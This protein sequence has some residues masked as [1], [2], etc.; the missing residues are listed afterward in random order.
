MGDCDKYDHY[1]YG[2]GYVP[3][4][5]GYLRRILEQGERLEELKWSFANKS[6]AFLVGSWDDCN[7]KAGRE[8]T[9]TNG[10]FCYHPEPHC[11]DCFPDAPY[12]VDVEVVG[13]SC[14][15]AA[16]LNHPYGQSPTFRRQYPALS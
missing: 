1:P 16:S 12:G 6:V 9:F 5:Y 10:P 15:T 3:S 7:C 13:G 2:L 14:A 4:K 8:G 11:N